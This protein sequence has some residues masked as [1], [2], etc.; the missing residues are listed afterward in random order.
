MNVNSILRC[1]VIVS[2]VIVILH[3]CSLAYIPTRSAFLRKFVILQGVAICL[4][5]YAAILNEYVTDGN[6]CHALY[7]NMPG[8]IVRRVVR[9]RIDDGYNS[10]VILDTYE[11]YMYKLLSHVLD[12]LGH[13]GIV[14]LFYT[15]HRKTGE[16]W[17]H[18][19][20]WEVIIAAWYTSRLWSV[21]HSYYNNGSWDLWYFGHDV[22]VLND[23]SVYATA[24]VAEG[25]CFG[26]AILWKLC[27]EKRG[28]GSQQPQPQQHVL[29]EDPV[30]MQV[31]N[32]YLVIPTGKQSGKYEDDTKPKLVHSETAESLN[33]VMAV[34]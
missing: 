18:I 17:H 13:P 9:G 19:L 31:V 6:F 28:E 25:L 12:T 32:D 29:S 11:A 15:I 5:W 30:M 3:L 33:S 26:L 23:T 22:Y 27:L 2:L 34:R 8:W 1:V 14:Y 16:N 4:G 21:V 10:Y 7:R 24:Y 20:S